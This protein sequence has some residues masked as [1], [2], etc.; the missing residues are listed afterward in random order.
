MAEKMED[1]AEE[2]H[3]NNQLRSSSA[4]MPVDQRESTELQ[5]QISA[6]SSIQ[7][8]Q[9]GAPEQGNGTNTAAADEEIDAAGFPPLKKERTRLANKKAHPMEHIGITFGLPM[10]VLFD[11]VV[12]CIIYYTV[13][14]LFN[15]N[16]IFHLKQC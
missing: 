4:G 8:K 10:I 12:P 1:M 9:N 2:P 13:R 16:S 3:D 11:I 6:D 14:A 15:P 5:Q 7:E